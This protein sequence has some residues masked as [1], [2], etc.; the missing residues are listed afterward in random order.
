MRALLALLLGFAL[1]GCCLAPPE[2]GGDGPLQGANGAS[3]I[4]PSDNQS[5]VSGTDGGVEEQPPATGEGT[6]IDAE[7][8]PGGGT[9]V[10]PSDKPATNQQDCATLTANCDACISK[11]NCGWCKSSMGCYYGD[12]EGPFAGQCNDADWAVI[13]QEC[14]APSSPEGSACSQQTN[15]AFCLSGSGCKW[16][17]QGT[18]CVDASSTEP[19]F[20]GWLNKSYQC[21]YA[22]R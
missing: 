19:C 15:C 17:I 16:C 18:K 12:A 3:E 21:N 2:T 14:E 13:A 22:S 5:G 11:P 7:S 9:T 10:M 4:G 8:G 20:G 6:I 1:M